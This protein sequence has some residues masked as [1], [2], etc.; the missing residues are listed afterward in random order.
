MIIVSSHEKCF[1]SALELYYLLLVLK[2]E[3]LLLKA[4]W[5]FVLYF[6]QQ[7]GALHLILVFARVSTS[8]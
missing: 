6:N 5:M 4:F 7:M 8:I 2:I 3:D 1:F